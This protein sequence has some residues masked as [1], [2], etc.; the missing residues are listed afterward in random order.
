MELYS[1][2]GAR[3]LGEA[4]LIAQIP[5]GRLSM[6]TRI[7]TFTVA[8]GK[9][10]EVIAL[11]KEITQTAARI[12]NRPASDV[13]ITVGGDLSEVSLIMHGDGVDTHDEILMKSTL[14]PEIGPMLDKLFPLIES[15]FDTIYRH[16]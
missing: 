9:S 10:R 3:L 14:H 15:G 7:R 5:G 13:A 1:S 8:A 2:N 4:T 6:I 12:N 11:L 16:V